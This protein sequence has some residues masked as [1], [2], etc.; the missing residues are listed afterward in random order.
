ME[1][2]L[3][4]LE[5]MGRVLGDNLTSPSFLLIYLLLFGLVTWQYQR[6][7]KMSEFLL[8][9]RKNLYLRSALV[10]TTFGIIGGILGSILLVFLG[11][12]LAGIGISQ[13]WLV[14]IVLMLIQ[15]RFLCFA[16]GAG[17]LSI[18]N[19]LFAY[20]DISI[21]QLMGLVAVLH[22]VESLLILANGSYRPFPVYIKKNGQLRGG[23]NLQSFWPIPLVAL[24]GV[25]VIDPLGGISMPDWWPL[26]RDSAR[27]TEG[28]TYA[29]LPVMAVLGYGEISTTQTPYQTTRKSSLHLFIFSLVLLALSVLASRWVLFLPIAAIFSPLGHE[30]VIWL[31]MRA[32]NRTPIYVPS[33]RG[34]RVLDVLP[35]SPVNRAGLRSRDVILTLNGEITNHFSVLQELLNCGCQEMVL[36]IKRGKNIFKLP[37]HRS[38]DQDLGII[39]VPENNA[40]R[41]LTI[42]EDGIFSTALR[43]WRRI[44]SVHLLPPK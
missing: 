22:L 6:L 14:A 37:L 13:L 1:L 15:P 33:E 17:L 4:I 18:S 19:L 27:F 38:P 36:E 42:S 8:Q 30:L 39:P 29:L 28:Q 32:E 25:G 10:S 41:Y 34:I 3:F 40:P 11:I 9:G 43:I 2:V 5:E 26:L 31:G 35:G 20:P 21:P 44:K 16:Y 23:F 12:D 7:Q 24:L